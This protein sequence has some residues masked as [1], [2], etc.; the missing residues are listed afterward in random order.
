MLKYSSFHRKVPTQYNYP[1]TTQFRTQ[2]CLLQKSHFHLEVQYPFCK[3]NREKFQTNTIFSP[4]ICIFLKLFFVCSQKSLREILRCLLTYSKMGVHFLR[5]TESCGAHQKVANYL[6]APKKIGIQNIF[7][8]F[9]S[10]HMSPTD[11]QISKWLH[12]MSL[13]ELYFGK[14][15]FSTFF[16]WNLHP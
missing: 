2:V 1:K 16:A 8:L 11:H 4:T 3:K 5:I 10:R 13:Q 7:V 9:F 14:R 15:T 6:C 12:K